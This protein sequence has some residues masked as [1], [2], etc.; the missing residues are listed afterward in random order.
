M[1]TSDH[2]FLYFLPA[3]V[4]VTLAGRAQSLE[5][6]LRK[7]DSV[8]NA[9]MEQLDEGMSG[10]EQNLP[11]IE[12]RPDKLLWQT[13]HL[14]YVKLSI[15]RQSKYNLQTNEHQMITFSSG[16]G[17]A[18]TGAL[19]DIGV[20]SKKEFQERYLPYTLSRHCGPCEARPLPEEWHAELASRNGK[21]IEYVKPRD[22]M[23]ATVYGDINPDSIF[24]LSVKSRTSDNFKQTT[25]AILKYVLSRVEIM[26]SYG[27]FGRKFMLKNQSQRVALPSVP[28]F[29]IQSET[30]S[31]RA[32][33]G[34]L[35]VATV[36]GNDTYV[37]RIKAGNYSGPA[38]L[39][40][41]LNRTKVRD[42]IATNQGFAGL[43]I[44]EVP[45]GK[46][47][48]M[49]HY[50]LSG[51][52]LFKTRLV[53]EERIVKVGDMSV[54]EGYD[55]HKLARYGDRFV[56]FFSVQKRWEP[57]FNRGTTGSLSACTG[58]GIHQGDVLLTINAKGH[59]EFTE[60]QRESATSASGNFSLSAGSAGDG[61]R[62]NTLEPN[63]QYGTWWGA[64]HSFT[65][66]LLVRNDHVL[67]MTVNDYFPYIGMA[68]ST[69]DINRAHEFKSS[70][71]DPYYQNLD[72]RRFNNMFRCRSSKGVNYVDGLM[73][74]NMHADAEQVYATYAK[75][76]DP[77]GTEI[78]P[79]PAA[80]IY[81]ANYH[82]KDVYFNDR[83]LTHT[84]DVLETNVKS[85]A[86][87]NYFLV[88]WNVFPENPAENQAQDQAVIVDQNGN[89]FTDI[90]AVNTQF[91]T[92][93]NNNRGYFLYHHRNPVYHGSDFVKLNE[94][95]ALWLRVLPGTGELEMVTISLPA[96]LRH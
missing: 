78:Y 89:I 45:N 50:N 88:S 10:Q 53:G 59:I 66:D 13:V 51:N 69:Y 28:D 31:A 9:A 74:G 54:W 94:Y 3:L 75:A 38:R 23:S 56:A 16:R 29:N 60:H 21:Y 84:P 44:E 80:A 87:G 19:C 55:S 83:N 43:F 85:I 46:M 73:A 79:Q 63:L 5:D 70:Y 7:V 12:Y 40:K 47:I 96:E 49:G 17:D 62:N 93:G 77:E 92:A 71:Y 11:D 37:H 4:I 27:P 58:N 15:P 18:P 14:P 1:K 34:D 30:Y 52:A 86:L 8:K 6:I 61:R 68:A 65:K 91:F 57:G 48:F 36:A 39:V 64:S 22:Y 24:L 76:S 42:I 33:N 95:S 25:P 67:R 32:E 82:T 26:D 35:Y 81:D 20:M 72:S 2:K 41:K 90:T